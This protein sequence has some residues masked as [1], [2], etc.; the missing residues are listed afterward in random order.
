[1]FITRIQL[2]NWRNFAQVDVVLQPRQFIV[3]PNASGKSNFLDAF[4]FLRDIAKKRGGG[5][6]EAVRKRGGLKKI[7]CLSAR[8]DPIVDINVCIADS[9]NG[10]PPLWQYSLGIK[11]ETRGFREPFVAYEKVWKEGNLILE[12]PNGED[13]IDKERQKQTYLEQVNNNQNFREIGLFF[14]KFTYMHLVPQLVRHSD[15][16]QGRVVED[17]PFGQGFLENIARTNQKT[18]AARLKTING[19]IKIAVPKLEE[20]SFVQD[21]ITGRPHIS[22]LY[23][24][25]RYRGAKQREDQFSDGT[26]RLMG[27]VWSLLANNSLLLLEEPE[28]SLH[29]E[30]AAKLAPLMYRAQQKSKVLRQLL[31]STHS[32][33]LLSDKGISGE[34]VLVL[35]PT[36]EGTKVTAATDPNTRNAV[37]NLDMSVGEVVIPRTKPKNVAQLSWLDR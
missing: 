35:E 8:T 33:E 15:D 27:L 16:I 25:W 12:R 18:R 13:K 29:S 14:E 23:S 36:E 28:L 1:M 37:L 26:L 24:H 19:I 21:E 31:V 30:I 6:Q 4:R 2:K 5:L 11:Q 17:D 32:P 9:Y 22:A 3:G 10:T 34:E 7:R 20:I